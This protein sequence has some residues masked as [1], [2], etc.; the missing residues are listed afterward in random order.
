MLNNLFKGF[1]KGNA[2]PGDDA[3]SDKDKADAHADSEAQPK[4]EKKFSLTGLLHLENS[5]FFK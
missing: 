5:S 2:G 3:H 4:A 1:S